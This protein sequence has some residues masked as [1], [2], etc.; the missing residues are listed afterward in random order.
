M[1]MFGKTDKVEN[2]ETQNS[3]EYYLPVEG[4]PYSQQNSPAPLVSAFH[5]Q[6]YRLFYLHI[7]GITPALT[8]D[9]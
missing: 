7:I 2:T 1:G 4:P 6:G 3:D 5:P 9:L 8:R